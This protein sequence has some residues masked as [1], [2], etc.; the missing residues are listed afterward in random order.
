MTQPPISLPAGTIAA[1]LQCIHCGYNLRGLQP[2]GRCP[3]CG[4]PIE[5]SR[6]GHLLRYAEVEWLKRL[7]FGTALKYWYVGINI[8]SG[9][10][11]VALVAAGFPE[12]LVMVL[13]LAA[14]A[15][16][17]WGTMC[18]TAQEPRI[19][20]QEDPVTVRKVVRG[21]AIAGFAAGLIVLIDPDDATAIAGIVGI[22]GGL[23]GMVALGGELIYYRRFAKRIPDDKLTVSTRRLFWYS[24]I[25]A[26]LWITVVGAL[27]I[28][29]AAAAP[30]AGAPAP[31]IQEVLMIVLA[32]VAFVSSL[33]MLIGLLWY[34]R[35][36]VRYRKAFAQ[37][38]KMRGV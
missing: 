20:L 17:L 26:S 32:A 23:L 19:S 16:S 34:V 37:A 30:A 18:I 27:G 12:V 14:G 9:I 29:S 1:D 24:V 33:L 15:L 38:I 25:V 7:R 11:G 4:G 31:P 6:Q 36:L 8:L 22:I 13:P 28:L 2:A 35:T 21:F 10:A 5:D 3:E